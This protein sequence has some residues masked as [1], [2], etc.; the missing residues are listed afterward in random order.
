MT[1]QI[2]LFFIASTVAAFIGCS[3]GGASDS[4]CGKAAKPLAGIVLLE[5]KDADGGVEILKTFES[6]VAAECTAKKLEETSKD[7]LQCYVDNKGERGY[8]I[9]KKCPEEPGK[10]LVS[11]V[12]AKHGGKKEQ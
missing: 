12:V 5:A 2:C 7:A 8:F 10:A 1:K 6:E 3:G 9:F 4:L 11:A